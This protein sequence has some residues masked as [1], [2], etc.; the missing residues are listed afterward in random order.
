MYSRP[1]YLI[2]IDGNER[3][4]KLEAS[5]ECDL[6]HRTTLS[7]YEMTSYVRADEYVSNCY[8]GT[9]GAPRDPRCTFL[10]IR[11]IGVLPQ[12]AS[13]P[14]EPELCLSGNETQNAIQMS[15][16]PTDSHIDLGTGALINATITYRRVS[17]YST[18]P[19]VGCS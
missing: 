5:N 3:L 2:R 17:P 9:Q 12:I 8:W 6:L 10:P 13:C 4:L 14:F 18:L 7:L 19:T 16:G 1:S 15:S 11:R